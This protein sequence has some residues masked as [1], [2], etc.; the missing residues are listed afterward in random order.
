[1][2]L[3]TNKEMNIKSIGS[4]IKGNPTKMEGTVY[5]ILII[6]GI[7][8]FLNDLIQS[9]IPSIYPII[10]D[11]FDFSFAQIGII[12][13]MFQMASSI[14]QPF[15]GLYADKHPR[16]YALSVGMCFTLIGL[17]MLAFSENYLLI[18]LSVSIVGLGSSVFHPTA[19]RVAQLASGGRKSLAQSIFQV[20]GNGGSA[21]GPLLAALIILPFGQH[22]ISWFAL[23]ALLA[24]LIMIRLGAWYKARLVYVVT[25]PQKNVTLSND[26]SKR[27]KYGA[28]FILVLLIFSKYFYT[29]CITSYF[30][31]FLIDK[32]GISVQAS[33]LCL[34]VFLAAFAIGTVAGGMLGDKFGRKYVIWF[35]ILGAAPF[36]LIMPFANLFWT[37]VCT[38][39][40]GLIIASAFS[41]IVVYATDLMPDKVGFIAGIFFGLMFGL[42]G[43]GSAFFGWLADKT[44][45]EFIFQVSAFLPLLGIIAGFLPNT[46]KKRS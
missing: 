6:C 29:S 11:K 16:P 4:K 13:L 45:I 39:L 19:S 33:Q 21:I 5:S 2:V 22:A 10:K 15:T 42:G 46:Q 32:F 23:A 12:T 25:H 31:F 3:K 44:S 8:H 37:L 38:F 28:L 41:S 7:S 17:L 34:F 30:T 36:A 43:L 9:I 18:L 24:A 1:M 26:I 27:A 40:S 20:G 35:S 14:L